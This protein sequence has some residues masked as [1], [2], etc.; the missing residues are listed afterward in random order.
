MK[1]NLENKKNKFAERTLKIFSE[2]LFELLEKTS[3][4]KITVSLSVNYK[5]A[6]SKL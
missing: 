3:F 1:Y 6:V 5:L 4:E 2:T